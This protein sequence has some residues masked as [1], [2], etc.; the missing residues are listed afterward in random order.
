MKSRVLSFV[1]DIAVV[2][3]FV[4]IGTR[5]HN[6]DEDPAGVLSTAAPF[7]VGL[8]VGWLA[9]RAWRTPVR[10][11]TGLVVCLLTVTVGMLLRHFVWER[12][13]A[14][15]FVLVAT[16]FNLFTLV[17]WRFVRE[18]AFSRNHS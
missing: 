3:L 2:V 16:V 17:G 12:G 13:I 10:V 11:S 8:C 15:S 14:A 9:A 6:T 7:L 4:F 18:N 1:A 5:N